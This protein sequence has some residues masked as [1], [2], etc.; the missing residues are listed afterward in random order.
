LHIPS[1]KL[2]AGN[3]HR[4]AHVTIREARQSS[5]VVKASLFVWKYV[6][7]DT[8][9]KSR[10]VAARRH[11]DPD[12]LWLF[13]NKP[14]ALFDGIPV[15]SLVI[16]I[17]VVYFFPAGIAPE[18]TFLPSPAVVANDNVHEMYNKTG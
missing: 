17:A 15:H 4:T 13:S 8:I 7:Y 11:F 1:Q 18:K 5:Y 12:R 3:L 10:H 2:S 6:I 9:Q 16:A 14:A